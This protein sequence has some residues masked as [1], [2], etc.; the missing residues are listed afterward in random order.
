MK[1]QEKPRKTKEKLRKRSS[2]ILPQIF[3]VL[4]PAQLCFCLIGIVLKKM[5]QKDAVEVVQNCV[6]VPHFFH[7]FLFKGLREIV[8]RLRLVAVVIAPEWERVDAMWTLRDN[9]CI[10][11]RS[12]E[13]RLE[14]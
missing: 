9:T 7:T 3:C 14:L 13:M 8:G 4:T 1:S 6:Y 2:L 12:S 11:N 10:S 5:L